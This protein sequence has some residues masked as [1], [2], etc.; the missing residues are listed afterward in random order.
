MDWF[1]LQALASKDAAWA[2]VSTTTDF[3]WFV[4]VLTVSGRIR[5]QHN[6]LIE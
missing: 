6:P 1:Q 2:A 4:I 3:R 5:S